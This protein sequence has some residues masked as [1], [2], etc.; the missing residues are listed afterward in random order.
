MV[1][2]TAFVQVIPVFPH[3]ILEAIMRKNGFVEFSST[4][5]VANT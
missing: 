1:K 5:S 3:G 2:V 4:L